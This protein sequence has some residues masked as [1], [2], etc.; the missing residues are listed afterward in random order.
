MQRSLLL[1]LLALQP[2]VAP[3]PLYSLTV[4]ADPCAIKSDDVVA[5]VARLR[6]VSAL[7]APRNHTE[8]R[9]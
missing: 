3:E 7:A 2:L 5:Q 6:D 1:G 8:A 4:S 9:R